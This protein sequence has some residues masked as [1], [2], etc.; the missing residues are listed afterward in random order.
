MKA[1]TTDEKPCDSYTSAPATGL[2]GGG[3]GGGVIHASG[4]VCLWDASCR[5]STTLFDSGI[6]IDALPSLS[7]CSWM[8]LISIQIGVLDAVP[9]TLFLIVL[10]Q[11]NFWCAVIQVCCT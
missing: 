4:F 1:N 5:D 6:R 7:L 9:V 2:G 10:D 3:G 8:F 11:H